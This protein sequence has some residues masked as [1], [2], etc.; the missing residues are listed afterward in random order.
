MRVGAHQ[1]FLKA[2]KPIHRRFVK[3]CD[4]LS[5][6][7]MESKDLVQETIFIML[8]KW[9]QIQKKE[10]ILAFMIGT[11]TNLVKSQLRKMK[12]Q[13][14]LNL[15]IE[16]IRKMESKTQNPELSFDLHLLHLALNKLSEKEKEGIILFEIAGFSIKEIAEIHQESESAIKTRLS[17]SRQK[18]KQ[19]LEDDVHEQFLKKTSVSLH[20]LFLALCKSI[21]LKIHLTNSRKCLNR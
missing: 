7:V 11:A 4:T 12:R 1:E 8:Q 21:L 6:G 16:A 19:M 13:T 17:R 14:R 3:Y 10:S 5:Y 20:S 18:L 9:E 2:Y 15:E